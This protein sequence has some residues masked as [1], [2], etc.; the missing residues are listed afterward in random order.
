MIEK[1]FG[2]EIPV[3]TAREPLDE[4]LITQAQAASGILET[5]MERLQF[6]GSLT[7]VMDVV[8]RANKYIDETMPWVLAR[9][10]AQKPRLGAV[11]YNLAETLRICSILLLPFMPRTPQ[12]IWEQLGISSV[13]HAKLT[14]WSQAKTFGV[15]PAGLRVSKGEALFPRVEWE[16]SEQDQAPVLEPPL[17]PEIDISEFAKLD[18]RVVE[19]LEAEK[20]AKADKLLKLTVALGPERRTIVAG[21]AAHYR[22]EEL[23]GKFIVVVANL[24][25]AKI[26]GVESQGMVLAASSGELLSI[27]S[28]VRA[29]LSA[30]AKVK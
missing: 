27:I 21:I 18:L 1:Y 3:A 19:V 15:L 25:P 29:G 7:A 30:G 6:G 20:V 23:V 28:P 12:R 13:E 16:H 9:D 5:E 4:E 22:P 14:E 11:L 10:E 2:G 17:A 26:R 8:K 24:K